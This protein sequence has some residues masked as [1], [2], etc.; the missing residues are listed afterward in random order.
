MNTQKN[1][2]VT[3]VNGFVGPHLVHE[4]EQRGCNVTGIGYDFTPSPKLAD[5]K[6]TYVQCDLTQ[7]DAVH[8]TIDFTQFDA[9]IHL[10]GLASQAMSFEQPHRFISDNS[11]MLINLFETAL[12][13]KSDT[14]PRFIVIS[15]GAVYDSEQAMPI[16]EQGKLADHSPYVISKRLVEH[17]CNYYRRRGFESIVVR[18]F[19]HSGPGQ[20][21]GYLIPDLVA[22]VA[23]AGK[24]GTVRVGNL[25]TRRDYSDVRDIVRG[26]A[27]LTLAATVDSSLF[28][29]SSG[30][31][32][33]GEELLAIITKAI[34]GDKNAITTEI[35]QSKIRPTDPPEIF[36]DNSAV[37]AAIGWSPNIPIETTIKDYITWHN[38]EDAKN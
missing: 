35:D 24:G 19:N 34:Y 2:L 28:N 33:S 23:A 10:A 14:L 36:G 4:L 17:L 30:K 9:V 5:T 11:A 38:Q 21:L 6:V 22:Q 8:A 12:R 37:Q 16:S 3:G 1:I 32:R 29:L 20:G 18:P 7:A 13:Q 25:K 15:S 26:Y 27:D 31:S